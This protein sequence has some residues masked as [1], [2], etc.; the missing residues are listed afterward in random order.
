MNFQEQCLVPAQSCTGFSLRRAGRAV[1]RLYDRHL[2]AA[3]LR[4]TQFTLLNAI[5]LKSPVTINVLAEI[6]AM[7]RTT[8]TRNLKPL[9]GKGWIK[10]ESGDDRRTRW[11][12]I[13]KEGEGILRKA[14]PLWENAQGRD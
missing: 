11:V 9:E 14:M 1:A 2:A 10:T 6:L 5:F 7:D 12:S 8:L 13:T 3:G 4:G